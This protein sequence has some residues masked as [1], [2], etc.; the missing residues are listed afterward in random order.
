MDPDSEYNQSGST[1]LG[2]TGIGLIFFKGRIMYVRCLFITRVHLDELCMIV[3][4]V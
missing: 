4:T 2:G 1:S 3:G